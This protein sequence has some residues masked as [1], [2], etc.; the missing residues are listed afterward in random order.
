MIPEYALVL[1]GNWPGAKREG[2][3]PGRVHPAQPPPGPASGR[4]EYYIT[5][6]P[7]IKEAVC[8]CVLLFHGAE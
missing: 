1:G 7:R 2:A 5:V 6:L 8:F 3:A 4:L